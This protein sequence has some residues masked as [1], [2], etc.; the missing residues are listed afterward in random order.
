MTTCIKL[1]KKLLYL[2][3]PSTKV[4]FT[5]LRIQMKLDKKVPVFAVC[6]YFSNL[7]TETY[8]NAKRSVNS[9][10]A[11]TDT[12]YY[13]NTFDFYN[14]I[15]SRAM[16][17]LH[18]FRSIFI[19]IQSN[20]NRVNESKWKRIKTNMEQCAHSLTQYLAITGNIP[21]FNIRS[22]ACPANI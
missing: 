13:K 20:V 9:V 11:K 4:P 18:C 8:E 15:R 14:P 19:F 17:T 2:Q 16:W 7:K 12:F 1:M 10:N 21:V 5:L 6:S 3:N 22:K